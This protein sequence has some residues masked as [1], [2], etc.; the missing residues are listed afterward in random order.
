MDK[1][2]KSTTDEYEQLS[3]MLYS[4]FNN[5]SLNGVKYHD[6][7]PHTWPSNWKSQAPAMILRPDSYLETKPEFN[8]YQRQLVRRISLK[9]Q[10]L[11]R[12]YKQCIKTAKNTFDS[13]YFDDS[14]AFEK[15][16][17]RRLPNVSMRWSKIK[18]IYVR[19][20]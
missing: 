1:R 16:P 10:P 5:S 4:H 7:D 8:H 9:Y 6:E 14:L 20:N 17:T 15:K 18:K 11:V 2:V 13:Y 19:K 3:D 12:Y